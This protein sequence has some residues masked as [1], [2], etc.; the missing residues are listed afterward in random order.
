MK[1][2]ILLIS[3][4]PGWAF[5]Q[6]MHDLAEYLSDKFDFEHFYVINDPFGRTVNWSKYN[7]IFEC[8]HRSQVEGVPYERTIGALRSQWFTVEQPGP[9]KPQDIALV[10]RYAAFQVAVKSAYDEI[11]SRCPHAVYLTNPVNM[12]RFSIPTTRKDKVIAEWNGN[13]S[14]KAA[15]GHSIK[16]FRDVVVP[17]CQHAGVAL[18]AAE[19][20]TKEG[21]F[22]KR[23]REEMGDLYQQANVALCASEYEAASNSVMEAM[24]MGLAVIATDVGNHREMHD[25]Q[26]KAFG[27]SGIILLGLDTQAFITALRKM[28]PERAHAMGKLN[29]AEIEARWSW[30]AHASGYE[31]LL[32]KAIAAAPRRGVQIQ[33]QQRPQPVAARPSSPRTQPARS[34]M[35][36]FTYWNQVDPSGFLVDDWG[37]PS[38]AWAGHAVA[39][40][41][42]RG[43]K[44]MVEA[45]PGVGVDYGEQ[46]R[47]FVVEGAL[48]YTG[49]EGSSNFCAHLRTRFPEATWLN[50]TIADLPRGGHDI[51]YSRAVLEH[52]PSLEPA[53][54]RFLGAAKKL[55]ILIWYRPPAAA[56]I[57]S[58]EDGVY[59]HTFRLDE[60]LDV[61]RTARWKIIEETAFDGGN[62]G[63]LLEPA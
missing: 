5:D 16:H 58:K 45:G 47:K 10:N 36:D 24:A 2:K 14:H 3:D 50:K 34:G 28:T 62:V 48:T 7:A 49:H 19:Y 29:R 6:N 31:A 38:R 39:A 15:D 32:R 17:V 42:G 63:W 40:A 9:P 20:T 52:Q 59:Y 8:Y 61:V 4:V 26:M 54:S 18:V 46:F 13:E 56:A 41:I 60:V 21:P 30:T 55:A 27:D 33:Q 12:H 57:S 44:T 23:K 11:A 25:A 37:N 35:L 51:V 1:P 22:R 43:C 53:L